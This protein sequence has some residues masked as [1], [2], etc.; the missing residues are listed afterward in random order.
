MGMSRIWLGQAVSQRPI[1]V[2]PSALGYDAYTAEVVSWW[3][4]TGMAARR[5]EGGLNSREE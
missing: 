1:C 5:V 2:D 4:W 3:C